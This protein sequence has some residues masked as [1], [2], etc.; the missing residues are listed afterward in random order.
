M[1]P[2]SAD[3][4]KFCYDVVFSDMDGN[5]YYQRIKPATDIHKDGCPFA[6][7]LSEVTAYDE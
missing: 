1:R 7:D 2:E 4:E 3:F 6:I 5:K